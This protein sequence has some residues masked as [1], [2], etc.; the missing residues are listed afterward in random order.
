MITFSNRDSFYKTHSADFK[1]NDVKLLLFDSKRLD[2]L[3]SVLLCDPI[4]VLNHH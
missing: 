3:M 4:P 2:F 1:L